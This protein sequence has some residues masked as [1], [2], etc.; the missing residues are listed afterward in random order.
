M[1]IEVNSADSFNKKDDSELLISFSFII[2]SIQKFDSSASS[3]TILNFA[4]K[5][6]FD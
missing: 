6:F 1:K 2:K 5:L 4:I 3:I